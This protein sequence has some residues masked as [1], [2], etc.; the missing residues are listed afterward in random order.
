MAL[1]TRDTD[2]FGRDTDQLETCIFDTAQRVSRAHTHTHTD[3]ESWISLRSSVTLSGGSSTSH[4]LF[5]PPPMMQVLHLLETLG[6]APDTRHKCGI[7]HVFLTLFEQCQK[8]VS[9]TDLCL[10]Q[11]DPCLVLGVPSTGRTPIQCI[12]SHAYL[13]CELYIWTNESWLVLYE[14]WLATYESRLAL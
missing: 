6:T 11:T 1:P 12:S 8:Y 2:Q 10:V 13:D 14:S 9:P 7:R 4:P 5:S 3:V